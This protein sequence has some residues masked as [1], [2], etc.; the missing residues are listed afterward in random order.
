MEWLVLVV[1]TSAIYIETL[2]AGMRKLRVR[3]GDRPAGGPPV[4]RIGPGGDFVQR[5]W[6]EDLR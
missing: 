2:L 3:G 5:W 4:V 6:P 1:L